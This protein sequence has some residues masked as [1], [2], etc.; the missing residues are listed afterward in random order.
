MLN[1]NFKNGQNLDVQSAFAFFVV[2]MGLLFH[3]DAAA[4]LHSAISLATILIGLAWFL[5][6][7]F[8]CHHPLH[9]G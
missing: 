4:G 7:Q 8:Y 9:R 3:I 6:R 1:A 5:G 2:M